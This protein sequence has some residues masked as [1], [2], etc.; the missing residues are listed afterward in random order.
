VRGRR[1][2]CPRVG[3]WW[4]RRSQKNRGSSRG[5]RRIARGDAG[6]EVPQRSSMGLP[7]R[8]TNGRGFRRWW[9]R[10]ASAVSYQRQETYGGRRTRG[11]DRDRGVDGRAVV[12]VERTRWRIPLG[13]RGSKSRRGVLGERETYVARFRRRELRRRAVFMVSDVRRLYINFEAVLLPMYRTMGVWG[14]RERKV[15]ASYRLFRYTVVG[16]VFRLRGLRYRTKSRGTTDR[17]R[18]KRVGREEVGDEGVLRRRWRGMFRTCAVKIPMVPVHVWL[19]EAHVEA[20]TGGSVILAGVLL[21]VGT[22]GRRRRVRQRRPGETEYFKPRV[23]GRGVRGRVY[24]ARTARR[25]ADVKRVVAYASVS[26]I[27]RIRLGIRGGSEQ[28]RIGAVRQMCSHGVVSGAMFRCVGVRYD[29][30]HTRLV[31][32]YGG[33]ARAMPRYATRRRRRTRGNMGRPGT[34][35]FVGEWRI[36]VGRAQSNHRVRRRGASGLVLGGAYSLW[37]YN[38]VVYGNRKRTYAPGVPRGD[39]YCRE[40][41]MRVPMT[42]R[43]GRVGRVPGEVI[44]VVETPLRERRTKMGK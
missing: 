28:G 36:R 15:R 7:C 39:R 14:T 10:G 40:R 27:N 24:T 29:R 23:Y 9:E 22:Y 32:Y 3:I 13:R 6:A 21:K 43:M 37:R 16:S 12:F 2:W 25:Q 26:H 44:A 11:W 38:R 8:R 20:T 17:R 1:R 30:Y 4:V 42:R 5:S 41:R 31:G 19:P 34:S 33:R 18:R 35:A